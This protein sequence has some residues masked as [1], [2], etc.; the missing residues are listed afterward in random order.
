[1]A[2]R[3]EYINLIIPIKNINLSYPGGFELF[4]AHHQNKFGEAFWHDAHLFRDG[5]MNAAE[6]ESLVLFWQQKGLVPYDETDGVKKWR[7]MCIV[8]SFCT[9]PTFPCEWLEV[10]QEDNC[11]FLRSRPKGRIIGREEMRLF[12]G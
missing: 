6:V 12:Y 8:E 7:D 5:A 10:D 11:V 9:E 3:L 1:M 4:R 2:I